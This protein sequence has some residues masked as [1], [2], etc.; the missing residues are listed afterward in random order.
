MMLCC[1]VNAARRKLSANDVDCSAECQAAYGYDCQLLTT[2]TRPGAVHSLYAGIDRSP[3]GLIAY[4]D[5]YR[6][7]AL[8]GAKVFSPCPTSTSGIDHHQQSSAMHDGQV[9]II[10]INSTCF[11]L[12]WMY[13][14]LYA[15]YP[16]QI[17][18]VEF[19]P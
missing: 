19:R 15:T 3:A 1:G 9:S 11:D 18:L 6:S 4:C 7:D 14:M 10:G 13:N 16:Q 12:S 17:E 5:I 8:P 2:R